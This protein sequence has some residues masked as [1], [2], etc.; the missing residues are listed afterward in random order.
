MASKV[1]QLCEELATEIADANTLPGL[2][3]TFGGAELD[4]HGSPPRIT[5]RLVRGEHEGTTRP[6]G[7]P[8]PLFNRRLEIE[9]HLWGADY[10]QTEAMLEA[11]ARAVQKAAVGSFAPLREEWPAEDDDR[12]SHSVKGRY[13]LLTFEALVP[14]TDATKTTVTVQ[15]VNFDNATSSPTDGKLD[16][17]E[18]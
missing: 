3:F 4:R 6:G 17:G 13:C 7:N 5:W 10:E 16:A 12:R 1:E 9:A 2:T 8:R 11:V 18:P 14:V 15:T